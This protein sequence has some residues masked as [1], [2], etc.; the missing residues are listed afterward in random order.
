MNTGLGFNWVARLVAKGFLQI[1]GIDY[2]D[3]FAPGTQLTSF[4][5]LLILAANFNLKITHLDVK[6]AFLN[7]DL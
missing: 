6:T 1:E 4:R 5:I 2:T 7:S 3:T